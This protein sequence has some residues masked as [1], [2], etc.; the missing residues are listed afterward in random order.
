MCSKQ[1]C[2]HTNIPTDEHDS[3]AYR[4]FSATTPIASAE[5]AEWRCSLAGRL[6]LAVG[7]GLLTATKALYSQYQAFYSAT[8]YNIRA[9]HVALLA[10]GT[11]VFSAYYDWLGRWVRPDTLV[12]G[13]LV[14]GRLL[15]GLLQWKMA[16]LAFLLIFPLLGASAG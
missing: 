1:F 14:I 3:V 8:F 9:Y 5:S 2:L 6:L 13:A 7:Y 10:L 11:A 12:G 4:V 15:L 16:S